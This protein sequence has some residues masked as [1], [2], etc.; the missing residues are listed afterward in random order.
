MNQLAELARLIENLVRLGTV[1]AVQ[2]QPPRVRVNTGNITT[3]WLP[4]LALRAGTSKEWDPPTVGEQ[5]VLLSPSGVLAQGVAL[6]G[7]FSDANPANGDRE[8]LHR[9]T[10]P[11]GAVVEYDFVAHVLQATL[12]EGGVTNIV[13]TG[14][15]NIDGPITHTGDY[16]QTGNQHVTGTVN[17][18]EDV[19]AA[20]ISLRNHRTNGVTRGSAVS[21]GPT[22]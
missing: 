13:S 20:D 9:R 14:G 4:W 10:Y 6:V 3:I 5:V 18:S 12:P 17:V 22:P 8:G 19:I 16:T 1:A 7:L 2:V 11:D 21:D 15:I